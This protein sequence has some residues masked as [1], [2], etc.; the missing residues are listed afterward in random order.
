MWIVQYKPNNDS[1]AWSPLESYDNKAKAL[2]HASRVSAEYFMIKVT[3]P[4]GCVIWRN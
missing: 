2:L 4:D 3:D 1:Q